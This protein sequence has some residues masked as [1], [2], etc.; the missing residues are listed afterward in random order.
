MMLIQSEEFHS[1]NKALNDGV[2][3]MTLFRLAV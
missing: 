3:Y 2:E 1:G